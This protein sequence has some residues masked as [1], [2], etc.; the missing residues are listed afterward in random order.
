MA[1]VPDPEVDVMADTAEKAKVTAD[2]FLVACACHCCGTH[3]P[4][5]IPLEE[6]TTCLRL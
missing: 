3:D 1:A 5:P 6:G 4:W 2:T